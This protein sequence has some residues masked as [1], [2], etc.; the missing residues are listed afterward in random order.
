MKRMQKMRILN[1][2]GDEETIIAD[3][4]LTVDNMVLFNNGNKLSLVHPMM[5][6]VEHITVDVKIDGDDVIQSVGFVGTIPVFKI[7]LAV[8]RWY[9]ETGEI[10]ELMVPDTRELICAGNQTMIKTLVAKPNNS[11]RLVV[12]DN[13]IYQQSV[14]ATKYEMLRTRALFGRRLTLTN[15]FILDLS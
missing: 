15:N 14:S 4:I 11:L 13:L 12:E 5:D 9:P 6:T 10:E 7:G 1:I 3:N 2:Q 8:Y